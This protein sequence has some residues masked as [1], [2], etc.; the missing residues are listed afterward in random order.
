MS[1]AQQFKK[2]GKMP[3]AND[4]SHGIFSPTFAFIQMNAKNI[5]V[6]RTTVAVAQ[7]ATPLRRATAPHKKNV[8][9]PSIPERTIKWGTPARGAFI[10]PHQI[11]CTKEINPG[12]DQI[13]ATP[14]QQR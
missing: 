4:S 10:L 5:T 7:N 1:K 13:A 8:P 9:T 14:A 3:Q 11:P 6:F 12:F 2:I